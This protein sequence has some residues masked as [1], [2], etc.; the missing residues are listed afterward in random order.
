MSV[1]QGRGF[2]TLCQGRQ[3]QAGKQAGKEQNMVNA[4]A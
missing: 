1:G 3:R 2:V 4:L